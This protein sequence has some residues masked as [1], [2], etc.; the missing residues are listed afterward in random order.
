MHRYLISIGSNLDPEH[1]IPEA[2]RR[3][4]AFASEL[5]V[6]HAYASDAVGFATPHRFV[7][8]AAYL[9]C[10]LDTVALKR[11]FNAIETELGRD[12]SAP[13]SSRRDRSIDLDI[14]AELGPD[15]DG[16]AVLRRVAAYDRAPL[17]SLLAGIG[18]S[19]VAMLAQAP[20]EL[21][22]VHAGRV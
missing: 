7:N 3:L 15:E 4:R 22:G 20:V 9:V 5:I 1:H 2:V 12:R 14:L 10:D 6:G 21:S 13:D 8:L 16:A 18:V 17:A 11:R 19:G